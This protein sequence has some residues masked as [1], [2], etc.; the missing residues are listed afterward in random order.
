MEEV[1][2]W[3]MGKGMGLRKMEGKQGD[4]KM[5]PLTE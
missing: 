5:V 1:R 2:P 4:T 3:A